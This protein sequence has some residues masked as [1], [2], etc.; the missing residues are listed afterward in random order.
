MRWPMTNSWPMC[1]TWCQA[2]QPSGAVH[3]QL[4]GSV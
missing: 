1:A 4:S 3:R 2:D